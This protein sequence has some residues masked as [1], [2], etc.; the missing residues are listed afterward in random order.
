R[1]NRR[2]ISWQIINLS[3]SFFAYLSNINCPTLLSGS[4]CFAD[5]SQNKNHQ[6]CRVF[7]LN[8]KREILYKIEK[9]CK[10]NKRLI[11]NA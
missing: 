4:L 3:T 11:K 6:R 8:R 9:K 1:N 10:K 5:F 2:S 7:R